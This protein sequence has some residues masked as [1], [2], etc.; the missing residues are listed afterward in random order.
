MIT[1]FVRWL[2]LKI[3]ASGPSEPYNNKYVSVNNIFQVLNTVVLLHAV[4][5]LLLWP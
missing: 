4:L 3:A 1:L 5:L 2:L